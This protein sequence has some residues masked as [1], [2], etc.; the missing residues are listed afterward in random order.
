MVNH[1][2]KRVFNMSKGYLEDR[3]K[4]CECCSD[5]DHHL[6]STEVVKSY[7]VAGS[8]PTVINYAVAFNGSLKTNGVS[9]PTELVHEGITTALNRYSE[10]ANVKFVRS[11]TPRFVIRIQSHPVDAA[12]IQN[13]SNIYLNTRDPRGWPLS[14]IIKISAHE[15]WHYFFGGSHDYRTY[16]RDGKTHNALMHPYSN[17]PMWLFSP[18]EE[19]ML[20]RRFGKAIAPEPEPEPEPPLPEPEPPMPD[21]NEEEL[22]LLKEERTV[23]QEKRSKLVEDLNNFRADRDVKKRELLNLNQE[24]IQAVSERKINEERLK[25][26]NERIKEL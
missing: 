3:F 12:G 18:W 13:G 7:V 1:F 5:S 25:E 11:G 19:S 26:I 16:A 20:E 9:V 15:V 23:L 10:I 4:E 2:I 22:R 8:N 21:P 14:K 6:N 24:I 17:P